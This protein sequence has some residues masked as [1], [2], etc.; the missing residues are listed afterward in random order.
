MKK[1]QLL[2]IMLFVGTIV[3]VAQQDT[4]ETII[5]MG[6]T[7]TTQQNKQIGN[8]DEGGI[9]ELTTKNSIAYNLS[10]L[11]LGF[12]LIIIALEVFLIMKKKI[13]AD[14]TVRFII[15]T[16]IITAALFLITAGYSNDQIAPAMGLMGAIAGY[17]LG[18][19]EKE[20]TNDKSEK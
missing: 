5:D 1:I 16:L 20:K 2:I 10:I 8:A 9:S 19:S 7:V 14:N 4:S 17:L 3:T 18:K 11:V 12:G 15:V 6:E 13:D